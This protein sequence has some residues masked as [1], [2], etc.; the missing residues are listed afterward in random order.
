MRGTHLMVPEPD[1]SAY[2]NFQTSAK[3]FYNEAAAEKRPASAKLLEID[4]LDVGDAR[5]Q[6]AVAAVEDGIYSRMRVPRAYASYLRQQQVHDLALRTVQVGRYAAKAIGSDHLATLAD[7]YRD[8]AVTS[9]FPAYIETRIQQG[10]IATSLVPELVFAD[11]P[12]DST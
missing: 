10:L 1:K 9:L 3:D 2:A 6:A 5:V 4:P 8:S 12:C 7:W 11:V